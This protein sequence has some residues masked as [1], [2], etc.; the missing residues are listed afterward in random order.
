MRKLRTE[1]L[2]LVPVTAANAEVLWRVLQG[3][4]LR[5]FQD[6]PEADLPQFRRLV[7]ARPKSLEMGAWGRFE[8]LIFL[9]GVGEAVGW[10]S[11][12]IAE[13]SS[14]TAEIGYSVSSSYRGRGIAAEAVR[15]LIDEAFARA[16]LRRI[17]A[18]C[19]PENY[20]S[21]AVLDRLGFD[22]DGILPH[23]ATVHGRPVDVLSLVLPREKWRQQR[24]S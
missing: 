13:R 3:P 21:R 12:R 19:V 14:A 1:R 7:A 5:T 17:R 11:L 2:Q 8:W 10:L 4:D 22:D 20:A 18:Y 23:G 6:L 9:E 24:A 15:G 16:N